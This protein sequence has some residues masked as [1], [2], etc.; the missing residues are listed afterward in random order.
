[1]PGS[2][3]P[4]SKN[5][6]ICRTACRALGESG[7]EASPDFGEPLLVG[8]HQSAKYALRRPISSSGGRWRVSEYADRSRHRRSQSR[9]RHA[10]LHGREVQD[11]PAVLPLRNLAA[12]ERATP[13][14]CARGPSPEGGTFAHPESCSRKTSGCIGA[15]GLRDGCAGLLPPPRSRQPPSALPGLRLGGKEDED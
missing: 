13:K 7:T 4:Q 15:C 11:T 5:P 6:E 2:E 14:A 1:M 9:N 8:L 10:R 3:L 12:G